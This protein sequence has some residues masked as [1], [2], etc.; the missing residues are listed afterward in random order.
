MAR[1]GRRRG[2]GR[3]SGSTVLDESE[4]IDVA[5][6]YARRRNELHELALDQAKTELF[7]RSDYD[8]LIEQMKLQPDWRAD[9]LPT[10]FDDDGEPKFSTEGAEYHHEDVEGARRDMAEMELDDSREVPRA[11]RVVPKR[12]Y[13]YAQTLRSEVAAWASEKLGKEVTPR[14]VQSCWKLRQSID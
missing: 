14:M 10:G 11:F 7:A 3:P 5:A 9:Y 12:P 8:H 2:A 1:G 4:M 6:E 13:S